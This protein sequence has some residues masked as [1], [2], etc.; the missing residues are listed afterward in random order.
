M[1]H[2]NIED[3]VRDHVNFKGISSS[4]WNSTYCEYCGDGA[5][6]KGPRAGWLFEGDMAFFNCFNCGGE[7]SFDPNREVP[8]SR[9]MWGVMRSFNIPLSEVMGLVKDDR[10]K[11]GIKKRKL[12]FNF[13]DLP[14]HFYP[15]KES[16]GNDEIAN[17]ARHH[18]I[19]KRRINPDKF[20]FYLSTGIT[21]SGDPKDENI[22][23]AFRN[24]LIIP[25]YVNDRLIGY[26]GMLLKGQGKKY[27]SVGKN[28]IHGY[29]NMFGR[30]AH[31][32][33]FVTE[34]FFDAYHLN[35][36]A[37]LT[38]KITSMQIEIL[39]KSNRPKIVVP[40]RGNTHNMLAEKA[41][42][43][44]W[45]LSLPEISP[46][47]DISEAIEHE[48]ILKVVD[49]VVKNVKYGKFAHLFLGVYNIA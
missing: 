26:E 13:I 28:L 31:V 49:S 17:L 22:A 14:D 5:R 35:G 6:T 30:D 23:K 43:L 38:N 15:L 44:G 3:I 12:E 41:L 18:L 11:K 24:R 9:D 16:S 1:A 21:K 48:G 34:G 47:K 42:E 4:G 46:H 27:L 33:I 29:N 20:N 19:N 39:N 32:P 25:A 36:V 2:N 10:P 37:V 45:G 7:A 8:M 40:D